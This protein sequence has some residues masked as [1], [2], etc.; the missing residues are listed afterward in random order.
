MLI[1]LNR[2]YCVLI[3]FSLLASINACSSPSE[4]EVS[5]PIQ[6]KQNSSNKNTT[7]SN[8]PNM[9]KEFGNRFS[10]EKIKQEREAFYAQKLFALNNKQAVLEANNEINKNNL[11][12]MAIP[13]GRGSTLSIPG[14]LDSQLPSIKCKTQTVEGLGDVLYGKNHLIYRKKITEYM[15]KFNRVMADRCL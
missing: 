12:L 4:N 9:P 1:N 10:I 8:N 6:A 7:N 14:I 15:L 11:Y 2:R 3:A 13:A 5:K